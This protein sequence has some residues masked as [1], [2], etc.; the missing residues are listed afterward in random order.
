MWS[1]LVQAALD[2]GDLVD[3]APGHALPIALFW[4]CWNLESRVL[5][6][7]SHALQSKAQDLLDTA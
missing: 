6:R 1:L 3:V 2:S 7:V 4:H 5:A